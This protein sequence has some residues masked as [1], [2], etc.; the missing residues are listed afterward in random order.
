MLCNKGVW[1]YVPLH[2]EE[3]MVD[4]HCLCHLCLSESLP[5]SLHSQLAVRKREEGGGR[6]GGGAAYCLL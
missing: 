2:G 4:C 3:L 6:G 5:H 1:L